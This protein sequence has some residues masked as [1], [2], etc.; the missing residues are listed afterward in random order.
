MKSMMKSVL[1]LGVAV[2]AAVSLAQ[3]GGGGRGQ[4]RG[5]F[6]RGGG[7]ATGVFLL[8]RA[9]V[10]DEIKLTEDQKTKL[11]AQRDGMRDKF[12][13]AMQGANGDRDAMQKAM[14]KVM[15][16]NNKATL[17][18]LTD[19][20]KKRLKELAIQRLGNGAALTPDVQKD[21]G[22]TDDQKAKIK[23]LQDKQTEANTALFEKVRNQEISREDMQASMKKNTDTLNAEIGKILTDAQKSKLKDM[24]GKPF[25]FKDET[26]GGGI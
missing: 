22:V 7:D 26:P 18:L 15:E 25:T 3:G 19:D 23:E 14:A 2:L 5:M 11:Q 6:G 20:Q 4:G 13:E 21:L 16:E 24:G 17:A 1:V 12:R 9:D 8:Q 10:S